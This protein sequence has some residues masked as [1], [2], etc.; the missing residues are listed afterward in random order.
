MEQFRALKHLYNRFL[1]PVT[2]VS[3]YYPEMLDLSMYSST[4]DHSPFG[5]IVRDL[6][7]RAGVADTIFIPGGGKGGTMQQAFLGGL[8]E[9]AERLMAMLHYQGMAD[10]LV[11]ATHD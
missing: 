9:V 10:R 1:G 8:G 6:T 11:L 7:V 5:A 3:F 4:C 2:A